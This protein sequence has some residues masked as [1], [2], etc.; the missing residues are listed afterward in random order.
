MEIVIV[1]TFCLFRYLKAREKWYMFL[2][3]QGF[4]IYMG[5]TANI[6]GLS[7]KPD[8]PPREF[9]TSV[10]EQ[11]DISHDT[12][13]PQVSAQNSFNGTKRTLQSAFQPAYSH[14]SLNWR[15]EILFENAASAE[16]HYGTGRGE[17]SFRKSKKRKQE[18]IE[19]PYSASTADE[20]VSTESD[21]DE[22]EEVI[23][24]RRHFT[25]S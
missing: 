17:K 7:T 20:G 1:L 11:L 19:L 14:R 12:A 5:C 18:V 3:S 13:Q 25:L 15:K 8:L 10:S 23:V 6:D 16:A 21:P 22:Q 2:Q 4:D 9:I 24:S